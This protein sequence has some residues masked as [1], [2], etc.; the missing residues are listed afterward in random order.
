MAKVKGAGSGNRQRAA[1]DDDDD[2][3][4]GGVAGFTDEQRT[5]L[6]QLVNAAVSGQ[7]QRKLGNA[8]KS[9]LDESLAP[10][11]EML[12][13]RN[14][15]TGN[16][17]RA[18]ADDDDQDDD[19][20]EPPV[21]KGKRGTK[22]KA[23]APD[24]ETANMR[25]RLATLEEERKLEREQARN[26]KRD[27]LLR[28]H[29]EAAGVDKNRIRGAVAVLRDNMK[30]DDKTGDWFYKA[31]RDGFE[32]DLDVA[33]GVSEWAG[34]DEGKS[35]IAPPAGAQQARGGSGSRIGAQGNGGRTGGVINGGRAA[36]D[37][38]QAKAAAKQ[39]AMKTL[40]DAVG[41]LMGG[42]VPLGG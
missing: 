4:G 9:T 20:D 22:A 32:E 6:G 24:P 34:T 8:I 23:A 38:K 7:L 19:D 16:R 27:A 13:G 1:A 41:G 11:R 36:V 40:T 25:K 15:N 42:A 21:T 31:K 10:I 14:G 2:D 37:P 39:E 18:A 29:L 30:H 12:E 28:E 33:D 35:Y 26:G 3:D 5:E 17:Q